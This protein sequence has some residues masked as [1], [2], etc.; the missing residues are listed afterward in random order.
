MIRS[1]G[2][3]PHEWISA[4][5][6]EVPESPFPHTFHHVRQ[7]KKT[8]VYEIGSRLSPDSKTAGTLILDL[9]ASRTMRNKFL[10]FKNHL[11]YGIVIA[12]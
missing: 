6:K 7:S 9:L 2:Q 8:V 4:L 10:L 12:A 5:I 1:R 11:V 3:S